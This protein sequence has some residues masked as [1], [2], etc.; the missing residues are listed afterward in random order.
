MPAAEFRQ[1]GHELVEWIA[2]YLDGMGD[3]PVYPAGRRPGELVDALPPA[4]PDEPEPMQRILEDFRGLVAPAINHWNHPRFHA[5]FS[6]SASGPGILAEFLTAAINTN[7]M[8]WKSSP[9]NTELEQVVMS[10][11]RQWLGLPES[12]FGM[13]HDTA[14]LSTLHAIA[15]ARIYADPE[16]R[17]RGARTDL[18]MYTSEFAHSSVEKGALSLGIGQENVRKIA[19]DGAFRMD[20]EALHARIH[21]DLKDG[22]TPFLVVSTVGT[23]AVTSID[24]CKEIQEITSHHNLWHHVDAA[25]GGGAA[26]LE[27]NAW[28]FDGVAEADSVVMNPHKWLFVPIDCSAF[29]CRWPEYLQQ[30][31][32]LVP[33]YLRTAEDPRAVNLMD[34]GIPLGRRFRA[35]KMWFVMRYFGR[36]RT[37][38]IIRNHIEWTRELVGW[39]E[40]D[41]RFEMCAPAPMSLAVFRFKG[42]DDDNRRLVDELNASGL[43]FI[44]GTVLRDRFVLRLALGNIATTREDVE[45]V[46]AK[47]RDLAPQAR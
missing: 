7:G 14:S 32:S 12:F 6:V 3:L 36:R 43:L 29:Y 47:I 5:F 15:A 20:P 23:T 24:P 1:Y 2:G 45:A 19:T 33:E 30:A 41:G 39:I 18:V 13:I 22:K 26:I 16:S 46:W 35:L 28:M 4:A 10:W 21:A 34:Y 27:E 44:G 9:A 42:S 8:L 11:L 17:Q 31:F 37:E 38:A 40:A 25:Y